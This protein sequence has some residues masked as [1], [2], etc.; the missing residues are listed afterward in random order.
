M[1]CME[2]YT[3]NKL[4]TDFVHLFSFICLEK[5]GFCSVW[6]LITVS[7]LVTLLVPDFICWKIGCSG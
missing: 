6:K 1:S 5:W 4:F 2:K 3:V 7:E